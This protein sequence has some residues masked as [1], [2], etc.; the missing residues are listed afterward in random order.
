MLRSSFESLYRSSLQG[1][2]RR[3]GWFGGVLRTAARGRLVLAAG[4]TSPLGLVLVV[5]ARRATASVE[6]AF[7]SCS[8]GF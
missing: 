3:S 2:R 5:L 4:P 6:E 8:G 7:G 1:V